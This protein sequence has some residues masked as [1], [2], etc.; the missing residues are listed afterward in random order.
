MGESIVSEAFQ[1][2]IVL[3][4]ASM[5]HLWHVDN[6]SN[7]NYHVLTIPCVRLLLDPV[8]TLFNAHATLQQGKLG[9]TWWQAD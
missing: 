3:H 8:Y 6:D 2:C 5:V 1:L 9:L 4:S 7:H